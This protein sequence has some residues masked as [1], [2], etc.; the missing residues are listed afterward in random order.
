MFIALVAVAVIEYN[1]CE[2]A[3]GSSVDHKYTRSGTNTLLTTISTENFACGVPIITAQL[4]GEAYIKIY[5]PF[6]KDL[7]VVKAPI[8]RKSLPYENISHPMVVL[9][10][11]F[12]ENYFLKGTVDVVIN[13]TFNTLLSGTV[14]YVCLFEDY[15]VFM[16]FTN[17]DKDWRRY[18]KNATC[19]HTSEERFEVNFNIT[20]PNYVFIALATT[21]A[22]DTLQFGY[23]GTRYGYDIPAFT[24]M[25]EICTLLSDKPKT[26]ECS[27]SIGDIQSGDDLCLVASNGVKADSSYDYSIIILNIPDVKKR[28]VVG[29]VLSTLFSIVSFVATTIF[30]ICFVLALKSRYRPRKS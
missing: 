6:C 23:N 24:N 3:H 2:N 8:G 12:G 27:F 14:I 19:R 28:N 16:D 22:L 11:D 25:S 13:A 20:N 21:N 7:Y 15:E 10:E 9:S 4:S 5:A 26:S 1:Y 29:A 17:S 30:F 18:V